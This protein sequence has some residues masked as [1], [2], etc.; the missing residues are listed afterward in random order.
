MRKEMFWLVLLA[1]ILYAG[2]A[3]ESPFQ[4]DNLWN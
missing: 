4:H 2:M 3:S 1:L